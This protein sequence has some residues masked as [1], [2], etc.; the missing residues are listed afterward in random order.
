MIK[1][2]RKT[3]VDVLSDSRPPSDGCGLLASCAA[4]LNTREDQ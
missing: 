3:P 1:R 4:Y 2:L